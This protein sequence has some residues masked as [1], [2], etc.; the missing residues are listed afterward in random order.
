[1]QGAMLPISLNWPH[2]RRAGN[3]GEFSR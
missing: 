3:G 2:Q 1:V